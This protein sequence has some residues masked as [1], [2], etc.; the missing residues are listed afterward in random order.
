MMAK[1]PTNHREAWTG[2][3]DRQLRNLAKENTPTPL[4]AWKMKRTEAAIRGHASEIDLSLKPT[5][6]APYGPRR[7]K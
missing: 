4:I 5:N 1:K 2:A 6:Q 3:D 7:K